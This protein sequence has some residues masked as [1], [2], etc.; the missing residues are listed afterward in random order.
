[1][2]HVAFE[3][4]SPDARAWVFGSSMPLTDSSRKQLLS[5]VDEHLSQWRA[6]GVPLVCSREFRDDRFLVVAVDES[7][8]GASGCS[9]D[10]L[11]RTLQALQSSLGTTLVGGGPLF[12]RNAA[13]AVACVDRAGFVDGVA[14]G[15]ITGDTPV[16]DLTIN[17]VHA[18][19]TSFEKSAEHSWHAR[20]LK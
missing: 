19:H 13:G 6:H 12:Y 7:A 3:S 9:I 20:L 2:P 1:M 11:F 18:W 10:G 15:T 8:T 16:F 5:A 14:L 17:N 4:L